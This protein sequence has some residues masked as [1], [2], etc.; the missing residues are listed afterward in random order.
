MKDRARFYDGSSREVTSLA[1]YELANGLAKVSHDGLVERQGLGEATVLVRYLHCQEP[2]R[3]AFVP[4]R[5]GFQWRQ[6]PA[7]NYIDE[8]IFAKLR[9][10][11]MNPSELCA[12]AVFL[13]RVFLDWLGLLPTS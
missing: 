11:R 3:L 5:P 8:H 13:R 2:V 7:R 10:L 4:A 1:V 12:D 6:P 9:A